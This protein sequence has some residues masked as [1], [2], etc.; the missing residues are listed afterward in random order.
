MATVEALQDYYG[1]LG[2]PRHVNSEAIRRAYV[3]KAWQHH[4]DL[5]PDDPESITS[6]SNV[7]TAYATLS[8]PVLRAEYDSR[9]VTIHVPL[10]R[11]HAAPSHVSRA[12]QRH[13]TKQEPCVLQITLAAVMRLVRYMAAI[14]PN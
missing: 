11:S 6:M 10:H 13:L 1:I 12:R 2:V 8:D 14:L 3:R 4:P 7:N 5:Y 9:R